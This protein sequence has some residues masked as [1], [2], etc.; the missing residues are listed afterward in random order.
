MLDAPAPLPH[1]LL[2][3]PNGGAGAYTLA[4]RSLL[5]QRAAAVTQTLSA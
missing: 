1:A 4:P 3:L 5:A 2:R